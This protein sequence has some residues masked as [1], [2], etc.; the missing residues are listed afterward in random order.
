MESLDLTDFESYKAY[1]QQVCTENKLLGANQFLFGDVEVGQSDAASWKGKKLWAWPSQRGRMSDQDNYLLTREA[2]VWVGGPS[3]SERFDDEDAFY[4][5][6]EK[7]MKQILSK[8]IK[9]IE[10][11][12]ISTPFT[13]YTLQRAD[14][15]L[16]GTRM[17]GC[18]LLLTW[19]D[20]E[21][22]EYKED[23]WVTE[24]DE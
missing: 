20:P 14:M 13:S 1:F 16:G 2:S 21:G 19:H 4:A 22:F 23:E 15:D 18:E 12:I 24:E 10:E 7:L 11:A 6:S 5:A 17:I 3:G 8:L 9:D